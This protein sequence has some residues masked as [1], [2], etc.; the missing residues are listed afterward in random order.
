MDLKQIIGKMAP[1]LGAALGGPFGAS[2]GMLIQTALGA[3]AGDDETLKL[4]L[5]NATPEQI[6]A[7]KKAEMDFQTRMAELGF[8]NA[9]ALE[10]IASDDRANARERE[11]KTGDSWT[12]RVLATVIVMGY[13][14]VQYFLLAHIVP[15]EMRELILRSLGTLDMA[16][17]LVLGYYF[18]SSA[19]SAAKNDILAKNK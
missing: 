12:P 19:S 8:Q 9:Q 3:D 7:L 10:K 18:G 5:G 13:I 17:G 1:F 14:A 2:A 16:L 15:A 4:A 6:T 11:A